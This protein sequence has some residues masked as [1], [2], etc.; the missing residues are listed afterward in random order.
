ME[1]GDLL[2]CSQKPDTGPL[3]ELQ[4]E[5]VLYELTKQLLQTHSG[6]RALLQN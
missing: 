3:L 1:T 5:T 6:Q 4:D 2:V